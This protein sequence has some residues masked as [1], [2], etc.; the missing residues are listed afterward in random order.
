MPEVGEATS[1]LVSLSDRY[2]A[3]ENISSGR[4]W[5]EMVEPPGGA[6]CSSSEDGI[7]LKEGGGGWCGGQGGPMD[8]SMCL[9]RGKGLSS[10]EG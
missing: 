10:E 5:G 1:S 7:S 8:L 2:L 4:G 3:L 9:K 6:E